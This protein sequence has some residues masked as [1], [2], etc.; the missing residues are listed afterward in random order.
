MS[1][2]NVTEGEFGMYSETNVEKNKRIKMEVY[3]CGGKIYAAITF[4]YERSEYSAINFFY[5]EQISLY[6]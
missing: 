6:M 5:H 4:R 3:V 1:S 2:L